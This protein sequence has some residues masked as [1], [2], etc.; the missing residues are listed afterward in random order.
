MPESTSGP[1]ETDFEDPETETQSLVEYE[2]RA[3]S[4]Q[5]WAE[6]ASPEDE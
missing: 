5:I 4:D 3:K 1:D 2:T 6:D